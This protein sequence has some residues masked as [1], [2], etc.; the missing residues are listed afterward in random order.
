MMKRLRK[1]RLYISVAGVTK[2]WLRNLEKT[3]FTLR[4]V[5]AMATRATYACIAVCG[6]LEIRMRRCVTLQALLIRCFRRHFA[7]PEDLFYI[8]ASLH[9]LSA[10]SVATFACYPFATVQH[11]ETGV[12]ITREFFAVFFMAARAGFL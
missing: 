2:L 4:R 5:P 9:V 7:E 1:S 11:C 12:R 10:R 8:T 3:R 6:A